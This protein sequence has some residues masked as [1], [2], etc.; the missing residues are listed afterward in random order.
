MT[1]RIVP[2]ATLAGGR[3]A[4]PTPLIHSA[5]SAAMSAAMGEAP[6]MTFPVE[7]LQRQPGESLFSR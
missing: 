6:H 4:V 3:K 5:F 7:R 1:S 2:R